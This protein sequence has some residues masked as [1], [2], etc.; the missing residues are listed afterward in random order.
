[1]SV[2]G[3]ALAG[4]RIP[5]GAEVRLSCRA[6]ANPSEVTY[7]WYIN[8]D[9]QVGDFTTEMVS[10]GNFVLYG[11]AYVVGVSAKL[12]DASGDISHYRVCYRVFSFQLK[13]LAGVCKCF[14]WGKYFV[15]TRSDRVQ[16]VRRVKVNSQWILV[17]KVLRAATKKNDYHLIEFS[18][19]T[20]LILSSS[21]LF[22]LR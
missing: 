2:I 11:A 19:E 12:H 4:G 22:D 14:V 18:A 10:T 7:R 3:G 9:L 17:G 1:M 20:F 21:C 8:D 13:L 16:N 6:D 15:Y 5:E